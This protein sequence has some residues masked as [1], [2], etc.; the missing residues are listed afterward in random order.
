[1]TDSRSDERIDPGQVRARFLELQ[2]AVSEA[3]AGQEP[4]VGFTEDAWQRTEGGGGRTR[5]LSSGEVLEHWPIAPDIG[6]SV[7]AVAPATQGVALRSAVGVHVFDLQAADI[8]IAAAEAD[9]FVWQDSS[10]PGAVLIQAI[11][12]DYRGRGVSF[13]RLLTDLHSGR[14]VG[15]PG[16]LVMDLAAVAL[17][18]LAVSG[19][20]IWWRR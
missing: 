6:S 2:D 5:V 8:S 19:L 16:S 12:R 1:M 7:T 4:K 15:L 14:L 17:V 18:F 3:L 13:E 11:E 9:E 20:I 10:A